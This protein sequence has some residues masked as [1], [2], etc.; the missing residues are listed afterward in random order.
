MNLRRVLGIS[1]SSTD[2]M[3][4]LLAI[5]YR[6]CHL[7]QLRRLSPRFLSRLHTDVRQHDLE[8]SNIASGKRG[9][10]KTY[11]PSVFLDDALTDPK[12]QTRPLGGFGGKERFKQMLRTFL[13]NSRACIADRDADIGMPI[14]FPRTLK[15]MQS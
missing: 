12:P 7:D 5:I 8:G 4:M 1:S 3:V 14:R 13:V 2:R 15:D 11:R 6:S 10:M 9:T